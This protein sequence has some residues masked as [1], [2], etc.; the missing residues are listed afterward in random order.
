MEVA[1]GS[2]SSSTQ[3]HHHHDLA[4]WEWTSVVHRSRVGPLHCSEASARSQCVSCRMSSRSCADALNVW[5]RHHIAAMAAVLLGWTSAGSASMAIALMS[6]NVLCHCQAVALLHCPSRQR[7]TSR[8]CSTVSPQQAMAYRGQWAMRPAAG[9]R[10]K[11]QRPLGCRRTLL[12]S[13]A[14][15]PAERQGIVT[16]VGHSASTRLVAITTT[17]PQRQHH[18][19]LDADT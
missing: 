14:E 16:A 19:R 12:L 7:Q 11:G 3:H 13:T 2:G 18:G 17:T 5:R 10:E 8:S 15:T 9:L 4:R 1:A 6:L